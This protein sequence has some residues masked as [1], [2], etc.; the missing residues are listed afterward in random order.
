MPDAP[1]P[2]PAAASAL[3]SVAA[4]VVAFGTIVVAGAVG[5]LIGYA[6]M[7]LQCEGQCALPT[8]LGLLAGSLV[9]SIGAATIA[10]LTLRAF[11]EWERRSS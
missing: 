5:G 3:P 7:S 2:T 9:C 4:R 6:F 1:Q 11:G 8:G 10:V